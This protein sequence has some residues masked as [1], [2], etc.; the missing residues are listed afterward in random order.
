MKKNNTNKIISLVVLLVILASTVAGAYL[1][2]MGR[3]TQMVTVIENG[4]PVEKA[5]YRQVAFIP[6][7]VNENWTE[8]IVPSAQLNG[9]YS[10][11]LTLDKGDM[12]D[13]EYAKTLKEAAKVVAKRG[14]MVMGNASAKVVDNAIVLTVPANEY[15][16]MIPTVVTPAGEV[17]FCFVDTATGE[18]SAP[19]LTADDVKDAGYFANGATYYLQVE[20]TSK[21]IKTLNEHLGETLYVVQDGQPIAYL[22]LSTAMTDNFLSAAVNDWSLAF[23]AA[24]CL[25]AGSLPSMLTLA[26]T[27]VAPATMGGV[28][29]AVI[30][31]CG[32]I[33]V[34]A[35]V[36]M[37]IR[38]K[39]AGLMGALTLAAETVVFWLLTALI[40]VST[41][42]TMTLL[43]LILLVISQLVFIGGLVRVMEQIAAAQKHR[44][45]AQ[46]SAAALKQNLKPLVIAFGAI[47]ALGLVLMLVFGNAVTGI[48]GRVLAVSGALSFAMIFVLLRVEISCLC[49][50]KKGN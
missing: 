13:A 11:T 15:D 35:A 17:T 47:L 36:F 6:N 48:L 8:A 42:W 7:P 30:V 9:G 3:N 38:A 46:A 50:L 21:A 27:A 2:I 16:T 25:R 45:L 40:S 32:V 24:V 26:D 22:T 1:G 14:E 49:A 5:L 12:S 20:V 34:L 33:A 29:D 43:A 31:I 28:L 23:I 4:Q 39:A 41:G 44:A 18:L 10:Y 19:I 37:I